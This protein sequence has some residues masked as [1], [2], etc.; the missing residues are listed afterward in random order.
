MRRVLVCGKPTKKIFFLTNS[1][2]ILPNPVKTFMA[3][4][5]IMVIVF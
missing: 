5:N 2:Q 3:A 1:T 4:Q